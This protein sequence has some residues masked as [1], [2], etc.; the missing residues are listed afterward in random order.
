M[1]QHEL[2]TS[3]TALR[4]QAADPALPPQDREHLEALLGRLEA[5]A[6]REDHCGEPGLL[7]GLNLSLARFE[8]EHPRIGATLNSIAQSLTSMGV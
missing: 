3:L 1:P 8:V 7:E 5:A 2:R 4:A 6:A